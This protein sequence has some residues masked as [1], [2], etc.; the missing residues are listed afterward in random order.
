MPGENGYHANILKLQPDAVLI[1][2]TGALYYYLRARAANP[3]EKFPQLIGD[4]S[5]N[6]ANHKAAD[7]FVDAG[8]NLVTP[9][10]DLNVQ[11][12]FDLLRRTDTS[13]MEVVIHQH[14]PMFHTE[15]CVYCTFLSEGTDF[16]NCGRPC[17][18]RRVSLQDRIGMSHP[19]RVDEGCRNTVYNAIEQSGAEYVKQFIDLGVSSFRI[20]FLEET[21]DKVAEVIELYSRAIAGHISGTQVW[22]SLKAINQL[23][24]TR[25]RLVK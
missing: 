15:H 20:E 1:R 23:G 25:G 11:Q 5:L 19:V 12:M 7:L 14:L 9:S 16:T 8:C 13:K 24:V 4:F 2:N 18:E 17:E 10:Y 3:D 22:R 21:A 6:I